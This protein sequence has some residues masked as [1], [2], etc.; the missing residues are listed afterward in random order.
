MVLVR[1]TDSTGGYVDYEQKLE[2][3][4]A[5][6]V[7]LG[8]VLSLRCK[9]R[10]RTMRER[11]ASSPLPGR[12]GAG[13]ERR[14]GWPRDQNTTGFFDNLICT[15]QSRHSFSPWRPKTSDG[16]KAGPSSWSAL[17]LRKQ[18]QTPER[19]VSGDCE[20]FPLSVFIY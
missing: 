5:S 16:E 18:R 4:E 2:Q 12:N 3:D 6:R 9:S 8:H 10:E 14:V 17:E 13:A 15:E 20:V 11:Q 7:P 1:R 19:V